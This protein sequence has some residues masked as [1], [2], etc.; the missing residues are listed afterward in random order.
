MR[1][2]TLPAP[3]DFDEWREAARGLA[4]EGVAPDQV[5]WRTGDAV[6]DLFAGSGALG[7]EA[8]SRGAGSCLFV[9]QDKAAIDAIRAKGRPNWL[10]RPVMA[11]F[12]LCGGVR[13]T[14]S[15]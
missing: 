15:G 5:V 1:G 8:L 14:P 13:M 2:V 3:D 11:G 10:S 7:L 4:A 6:A 12:S 9:E